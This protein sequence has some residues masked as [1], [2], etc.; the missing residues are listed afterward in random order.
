MNIFRLGKN[1]NS[2]DLKAEASFSDCLSSVCLSINF[3]HFHL[4]LQNHWA[5]FNQTWYEASLAKGNLF[6]QMKGQAFFPKRENNEIAKI[7]CRKFKNLLSRTTANFNQHKAPLGEWV[8]VCT[9]ME[10]FNSQKED[11]GGFFY[12][13]QY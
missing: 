12:P 9:N 10:P 11:Y 7:H 1:F 6:L 5:N 4:F 3:S 8:Q 13:N 2:P